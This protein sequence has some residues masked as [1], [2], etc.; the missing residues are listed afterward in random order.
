MKTSLLMTLAFLVASVN[1]NASMMVH[2]PTDPDLKWAPCP[3]IFPKGCEMAVLQGN[4]K[5]QHADIYLKVP[6]HYL[7]PAHSHTSAEHLT[8]VSGELEVKYQG[9]EPFTMKTGTYAYGPEK[10]PHEAKCL[11]ADSCVLY[12]GFEKAI[13][14]KPFKGK[15]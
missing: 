14:A 10:K 15:L 9:E 8:L 13:D 4:P 12:V 6:S 11:S 7:I 3:E 2:N 5:K 1:A